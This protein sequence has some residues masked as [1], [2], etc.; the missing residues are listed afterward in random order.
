MSIQMPPSEQEQR[1]QLNS[2]AMA[3]VA[4]GG[5]TEFA[6]DPGI[7]VAGKGNIVADLFRLFGG[8][9]KTKPKGN[10]DAKPRV[11]A[12]GN[13]EPDNLDYRATQTD[14]AAR[15]L[16]PEGQAKFKEQGNRATDQPTRQTQCR[17]AC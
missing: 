5:V 17:L 7:Q 15:N 8:V 6:S 1:A 14:A 4:Q 3:N 10:I 2:N 13:I 11:P 16:S 12:E 9:K